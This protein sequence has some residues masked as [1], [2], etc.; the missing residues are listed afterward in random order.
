MGQT[1][2]CTLV[3]L[4][5]ILTIGCAYVEERYSDVSNDARY[6]VSYRVGTSY[7]LRQD[8]RLV[9]VQRWSQGKSTVQLELWSPQLISRN[10]AFPD[11][12]HAVI[13]L[14]SGTVIHVDGLKYNYTFAIPP[15]P[16]DTE[17]L[18]AFGTIECTAGRWTHVRL[19]DDYTAHWSFV[20]GTYVMASPVDLAFLAPAA[21][22]TATV[23]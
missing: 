20:P 17:T 5:C 21:P 2:V 8:G 15:V 9:E 19:P 10:A 4:L 23:P 12:S 3:M 22:S 11:A 18:R 6:A 1:V 13:T 16:G 7:R 14:R